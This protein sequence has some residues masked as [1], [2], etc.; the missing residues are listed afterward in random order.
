MSLLGAMNRVAQRVL[1]VDDDPLVRESLA[2]TLRRRGFQVT[3]ADNGQ[4]ALS[5]L[6]KEAFGA[7][8]TDVRMPKLNGIELL[9]RIKSEYPLTE[10]IVMTAFGEIADAKECM[11]LGAWDYLEKPVKGPELVHKLQEALGLGPQ[12]PAGLDEI[13]TGDPRML[14]LLEMLDQIGQSSASV[15]LSGESGTGKEVFARAIHKRSPRAQG[16]FVAVNCAALPE[17][18]LE[19]ELFGHEK[20][21][22]TGAIATRKGKFELAHGGTLLLD[23][24]SEMPI[25]LQA[26]LLRAIQEREID[27]VGGTRPIRVDVRIIATTNRDLTEMIRKGSFREDLYYRLCVIPLTLPP[28]RE[29]RGDIPLLAR[30]FLREFAAQ[31]GKKITDFTDAAMEWLENHP[32]PGNVRQ[33][34]N[35]IERAV[36][37]ARGPRIEL[38]DL[39][40]E[41]LDATLQETPEPEA[42]TT[43]RSVRVDV[44]VGMT[45]YEAERRLILQTLEE[46]GGNKTRAAEILGITPRTIRN[47]LKEYGI[48]ETTARTKGKTKAA[49]A[50]KESPRS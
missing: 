17:E 46:C 28:L 5:L 8:V 7:V 41:I 1:L 10:V 15:L 12:R 30:H 48:T 24:I 18:L 40:P 38:R 11:R 14:R 49:S 19:S 13:V 39:R 2:E 33:L 29:R 37:F 26:K 50:A 21:A 34:R 35:T 9:R 4:E 47:K 45:A 20:G 31:N 32:W 27:R 43:E 16:P 25:P 42:E 44:R 36:V 3:E 23:E 6:Q 22:F